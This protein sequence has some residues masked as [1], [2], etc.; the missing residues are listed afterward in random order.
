MYNM[1][2]DTYTC[3]ICGF[4]MPWDKTDD[5]RGEMWGCEKCGKTFCSKCFID[6][7]GKDVYWDMM[8]NHDLVL[9]PECYERN[10]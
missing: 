6:K 10:F 9:C 3:D 2:S 1:S 8:K 4:E 5:R 7:L